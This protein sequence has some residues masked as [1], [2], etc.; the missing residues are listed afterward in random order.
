MKPITT[1]SLLEFAVDFNIKFMDMRLLAEAFRRKHLISDSPDTLAKT[2]GWVGLGTYAVYSKN[3]YFKPV[4]EKEEFIKRANYWWK[5][6]E[7][8]E[9]VMK[10]MEDTFEI[11]VLP[12][13]RVEANQTLFTF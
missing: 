7:D 3:K 11:P 10:H 2:L 12:E 13:Q 6:S 9:R 5:L 1:E 8:G 4:N